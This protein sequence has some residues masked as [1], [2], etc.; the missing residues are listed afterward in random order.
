MTN[1]EISEHTKS[2]L[3][4]LSMLESNTGVLY[5]ALAERTTLPSIK[6]I[7][8][9]VAADS[10]KHAYLLREVREKLTKSQEKPS[11]GA[12]IEEVFNIT[13]EIFREIIAKEE[14]ASDELLNLS[15]KLDVLEKTLGEKYEYVQLKTQKLADKKLNPLHNVSL[16]NFGSLFARM[17][18]DGERHRELLEN[19]KGIVEQNAQEIRSTTFV[20]SAS[21]NVS[22]QTA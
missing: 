13:Y 19:I 8:L 14:L 6:A 20:S 9:D 12:K 17:I 5:R 21:L 11:D 1:N 7:L 2:Y 22:A 10:Q 16:D 15:G 3:D 4:C 18:N